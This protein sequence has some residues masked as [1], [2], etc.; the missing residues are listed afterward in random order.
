MNNYFITGFPGYLAT[1]MTK[2]LLKRNDVEH[3]YLF[4]LNIEED[5]A[6]KR[7]KGLLDDYD[8]K[9]DI[10]TGDITKKYLGMERDIY[11]KVTKNVTHLFHLAA[12]YDLA[13]P[14]EPAYQVNVIGTKNVTDFARDCDSLKNYI[15]F[16][17]AYVSGKREGLIKET[18]LEH[19]YEFKNH[20]EKTKYLAELELQKFFDE[21]PVTV[22]RPGIVVG[23]SKTGETLKFDGPY[24]ILNLFSKLKKLPIIPYIGKS[25][26]TVNLVPLDYFIE[27]TL[28]LSHLPRSKSIVYHVTDPNPTTAKRL[29]Q[30]FLES[31][32]GKTPKGRLPLFLANLFMSIPMIRN[33]LGSQ[34]ETIDYLHHHCKFDT[35]N[36]SIDLAESGIQF[37]QFEQLI[38]TLVQYYKDV[39]KG[40]V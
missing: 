33:W 10:I 2:E 38:P 27:A 3:I 12:I 40:K 22:I 13:V 16:S 18:E 11:T 8:A 17:T 9:I 4:A 32:A 26:A 29:Y 7:L 37:P 19:D 1:Y 20:Y 24:Y 36:T 5:L 6:K 25:D 31:Y 35:T 30:L 28:Y 15:Y 34:R 14:Y 39:E 23:H 21:L